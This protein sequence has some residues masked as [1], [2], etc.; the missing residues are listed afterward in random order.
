MLQKVIFMFKNYNEVVE[1]AREKLKGICNVCPECNGIAC[2][3]KVPGCGAKGSGAS[4]TV[5]REVLKSI[6]L[7]MDAVHPHFEADTKIELFGKS[8]DYPFFVAPIGG[9]SLNYKSILTEAEY[10]RAVVEGSRNAGIFAFTGDGP[11]E[12]YFTEPLPIIKE[13]GGVA[14]PTIKPWE[15]EKCFSR[16]KEIEKT[17]AMAFA[18][19]V[20]SAS[21]INLKLLGKPVFTKS[22]EELKELAAC[23][24]LPFIV[25]GILT[26]KAAEKCAK[27]GCYG[28]VVSNHAGRVMEDA[29]APISKLLEIRSAVGNELK[30]F[31]DGGF[32]NGADIF[33]GLA[34][35]ADAVLLG[36]PFATA[37][38]GGGSEGVAMLAK[39]LGAELSE[40]MLMTDA[41]SIKDI[42]AEKITSTFLF[43]QDFFF[44]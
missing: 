33:K 20:D 26:A 34:L 6:K 35:G 32:R 36:R 1:A 8:F 13:F 21:L 16:I 22:E 23:T 30:I 11:D 15:Q 2:K 25:K 44:L 19:D 14:I 4:F 10:V 17:G 31:V 37:A 38:F 18:M 43:H 7:N 24:K 9:M 29:P 40:T 41:P 12:T 39:K 28:I 3:G 27:A 5:C 42:T